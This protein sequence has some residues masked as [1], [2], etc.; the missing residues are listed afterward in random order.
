MRRR[1]IVFWV[2]F[3]GGCG[4][5]DVDVD[6]DIVVFGRTWWLAIGV[7]AVFW[8]RR[9]N[10]DGNSGMGNW[11]WDFRARRHFPGQPVFRRGT[12]GGRDRG[13]TVTLTSDA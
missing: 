1:D 6:I 3:A 11:N 10:D 9:E 12:T 8:R 5:V 4:A 2:C 7:V 13:L